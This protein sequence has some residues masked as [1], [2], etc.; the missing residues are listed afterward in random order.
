MSRRLNVN[1]IFAILGVLSLL[2][3]SSLLLAKN[4]YLSPSGNDS[5]KGLTIDT[6]LKTFNAA[7]KIVEPGDEIRLLPGVYFKKTSFVMNVHGGFDYTIIIR[8]HRADTAQYG[9]ID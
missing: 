5:S 6:P 3:N 7:F 1:I 4:I 8:N 2:L 9:I